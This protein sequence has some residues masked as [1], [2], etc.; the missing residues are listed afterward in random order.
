MTLSTPIKII[1]ACFA[2][3][4]LVN[5]A[6][7]GGGETSAGLKG[8][9]RKLQIQIV[10]GEIVNAK[11]VSANSGSIFGATLAST[12][13]DPFNSA[14]KNDATNFLSGNRTFAS[15]STRTR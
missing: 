3:A 9:A 1:V 12:F 6:M 2:V 8:S 15:N 5:T 7:N 10:D 4:A 13:V 11:S 14:F